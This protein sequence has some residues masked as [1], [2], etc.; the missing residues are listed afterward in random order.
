M[1][2]SRNL[3]Q[4]KVDMGVFLKLD[5]QGMIVQT[6]FTNMGPVV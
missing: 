6:I 5:P 4:E 1:I 2:I 3:E